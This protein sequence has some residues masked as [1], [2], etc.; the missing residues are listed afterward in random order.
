MVLQSSGQISLLDLQN[1]FG[2]TDPVMLSEYFSDGS[3]ATGTTDIPSSGNT[4]TLAQF[5]GKSK[6]FNIT[7]S[8]SYYSNLTR[9][10]GSS[11]TLQQSGTNP[12]VQIQMNSSSFSGQV[13]H[14]YGQERLQDFSSVEINFEVFI[15]TSSVADALWFYMGQ[16]ATPNSS[17]SEGTTGTGY[18]LIFEVFSGNGG[19]PR[20]I[21]LFRDGNVSA[22]NYSTTSHIASQWIPVKIVYNRSTTNTWSVSWNGSTIITYS[23]PNHATW[24]LNSGR[25]WGF[26]SRTG[27]STGDF[28]I[29]R[30]NVNTFSGMLFQNTVIG[31]TSWIAPFTGNIKVLVVAGGGGSGG[32]I[33]GGGGGGGVIYDP[34]VAVTKGTSYTITVGAGGTSGGYVSAPAPGN[35][36]NSVF[37]SYIAIGGGAGG[38]Y[39]YVGGSTGGS[40]GGGAGNAT[41]ST[42]TNGGSGTAEQGYAGGSGYVNSSGSFAVGGGGGGAGAVGGNAT[43]SPG[44]IGGGGGIGYLS[45]ITGSAVYYGGGGGGGSR[46]SS[47][48]TGGNGGGGNGAGGSGGTTTVTAI[49]GSDGLGGGAGGGANEA[50][51]QKGG[52]GVIILAYP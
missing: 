35:G 43:N 11:Y 50:N 5:F 22:V 21:N 1:E 4:I 10:N 44:G 31:T 12:N 15:S 34:S 30:V 2:G 49:A 45:S 19:I 24:L 6:R 25:F 20:G 26:G 27:G 14:F 42:V 16:S 36:G 51:G 13:T 46:Y 23:D 52:T 47:G 33:A 32:G 37:G 8:D 17:Q 39:S 18:Q 28:Y 38:M 48:G 29:R 7:N 9:V 40:G 3:F 41:T